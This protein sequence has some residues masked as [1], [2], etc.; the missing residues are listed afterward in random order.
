METGTVYDC[1]QVNGFV[2]LLNFI[3]YRLH[4]VMNAFAVQNPR[5]KCDLGNKNDS[6]VTDKK[7]TADNS[8]YKNNKKHF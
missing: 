2:Y 8:Y 4:N 7:I 3:T 6:S 5:H 1:L